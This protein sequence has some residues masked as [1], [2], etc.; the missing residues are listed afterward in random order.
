MRFIKYAAS[1]EIS[2][3]ARPHQDVSITKSR[4]THEM[5][6]SSVIVQVFFIF[7]KLIFTIA[8]I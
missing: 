2:S 8:I 5:D 4:K 6:K 7:R 1:L 3:F